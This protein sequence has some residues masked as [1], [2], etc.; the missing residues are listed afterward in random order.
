MLHPW[1]TQCGHQVVLATS[2]DEG[3]L[4]AV[5]ASPDLILI[6]T[7]LPVIDGWQAINILKASTV[8]QQI[9]VIALIAAA[10]DAEWNR[11]QDAHC[12]ACELKPIDLASILAKI[13]ILLN[14][15]TDLS[16][17]HASGKSVGA[18]LLLFPKQSL[19]QERPRIAKITERFIEQTGLRK[20]TVVYVD[21]S[22]QDSQAL[23]SI[24]QEAGYGYGYIS[25]PLAAIPLLL[26]IQPK[27]I[28]LDLMMPYTN[29]YEMC[30][31]IRRAYA[32][33]K[34]PVVI[35]TNNDG[36]VDRMRAKIVGASG[37]CSKPV[38][39]GKILKVL[40]KY[41]MPDSLSEGAHLGELLT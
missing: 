32:L 22:P 6:D 10:T 2:G 13:K 38:K 8:T 40:K 21:D 24:I 34:T 11:A 7:E 25:D 20:P 27:L 14:R 35:L 15:A 17:S 19:P 36:I 18:S 30:A 1:L 41:L 31:Q 39:K 4:L 33:Q 12:D 26:E 9:P 23:A 37:F 16:P 3:I 5:T 29:G 28:F